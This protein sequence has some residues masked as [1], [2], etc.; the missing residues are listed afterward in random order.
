MAKRNGNDLWI[1]SEPDWSAGA[2]VFQQTAWGGSEVRFPNMNVTVPT[3]V[4]FI[5][6]SLASGNGCAFCDAKL[7]VFFMRGGKFCRIDNA[8]SVIEDPPLPIPPTANDM[9]DGGDLLS[10]ALHLADPSSPN[11]LVFKPGDSDL[12]CRVIYSISQSINPQYARL[13]IKSYGPSPTRDK[14]RQD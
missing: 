2:V 10:T 14:S 7:Y 1:D 12:I 3:Q 11:M 8:G 6:D 13:Q 9:H 4:T 5:F